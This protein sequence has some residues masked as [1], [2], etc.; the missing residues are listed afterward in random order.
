MVREIEWDAGIELSHF[1]V[2]EFLVLKPEEVN[3]PVARK[4]L[5][6]SNDQAFLVEACM[7]C[8]MHDQFRDI[9]CSTW[10]DIGLLI[11]DH[12]FY[13]YVARAIYGHLA[14][15]DD[16]DI[17][18]DHPI[19]RFFAHPPCSHMQLWQTCVICLWSL[20]EVDG[21]GDEKTGKFHLSHYTLLSP[22]HFACFAGLRHQVQRL[23]LED[24][25][26]DL[27]KDAKVGITALHLAIASGSLGNVI[28]RANHLKIFDV[29]DHDPSNELNETDHRDRYHRSL[30]TTNVIVNFGADVNR[31]IDLEQASSARF[32]FKTRY[33]ASAKFI[34]TTPLVLAICCGNWE[35][36]GLLLDAGA[37]WDATAHG[38]GKDYYDCCSIQRLLENFPSSGNVV[39]LAIEHS[40]R[41]ELKETLEELMTISNTNS[42]NDQPKIDIHDDPSISYSEDSNGDPQHRFVTAFSNQRWRDVRELVTNNPNLK[43]DCTD[44]HGDGAVHYAAHCENDELRFLLEHG[45]NPNLCSRWSWTAFNTAAAK[46]RLENMTCL[47]EHGV[48]I[49]NRATHGRT[50]LHLAVHSG[51]K[52]AVKL[53][54]DSKADINALEDDGSSAL[55]IAI[56]KGRTEIFFDLIQREINPGLCDNYGSTPLHIACATGAVDQVECLLSLGVYS[57]DSLLDYNSLNLGTPLYIA[58]ESG[59]CDIVKIL[60]Q[61]GASIDKCGVGNQF[62]SALMAACARGRSEVVKLLLSRSAAIEVEGSRFGS[63][64]GTAGAFRKKEI[65]EILEEHAK[66]PIQEEDVSTRKDDTG[67]SIVDGE[68]EMTLSEVMEE[69]DN[70]LMGTSHASLSLRPTDTHP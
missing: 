33:P 60:L 43:L 38:D 25:S 68:N 70:K 10:E 14:L 46:G 9:K 34:R 20:D 64:A 35:L 63:A 18:A 53:L 57:Q 47:L 42:S 55:H 7:T 44:E 26:P 67:A 8:L 23:L 30:Q 28:F 58:A 4:Y 32:Q 22:L 65:L 41:E 3:S 16:S 11:R 24:V 19:R 2:K 6:D 48:D 49:E 36:A 31:Q 69:P 12:P 1:T 40:S 21:N 50:P 45:A 5:V 37:R 54:L 61:H 27:A 17:E 15:F 13:T 62:G 39:R 52:D 29:Y 59:H 56:H 51:H 66:T